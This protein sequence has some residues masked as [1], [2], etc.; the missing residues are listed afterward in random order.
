M[1]YGLSTFP[2][3]MTRRIKGIVRYDGTDFAGWQVQPN[4]WTIQAAL[5]EKLTL[6]AGQAVR[7]IGSGR[8]DS[9]VYA[10]GQ[11]ISFDWPSEVSLDRLRRS[12]CQMLGPAI[13][14]ERL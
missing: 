12:L 8:T 1:G 13:G 10:L 7:V 11:V 3:F 6:I 2:N 9:G 4:A 5:E 14:V